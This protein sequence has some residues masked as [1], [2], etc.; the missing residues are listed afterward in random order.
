MSAEELF[1]IRDDGL[2]DVYSRLLCTC[3][4]HLGFRLDLLR[5][6]NRKEENDA[7]R[8]GCQYKPDAGFAGPEKRLNSCLKAKCQTIM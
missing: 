2:A 8:H 7:V 3:R 1:S 5:E 4:N 6:K